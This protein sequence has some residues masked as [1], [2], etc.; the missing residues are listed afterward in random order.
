MMMATTA[1]GAAGSLMQKKPPAPPKPETP[2][3]PAPTARAGEAVVRVGGDGASTTPDNAPE[4][5]QFQETR[6]SGKTLGGLG[7]G[8]LGL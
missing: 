8:G 6:A 1:F 4:Y 7:R 3:T 2:A 5:N